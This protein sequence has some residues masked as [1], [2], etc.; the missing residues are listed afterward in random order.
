MSKAAYYLP[1]YFQVLGSSAT[2]AGVRR[3]RLTVAFSLV[4]YFLTDVLVQNAAVLSW[5]CAVLRYRWRHHYQ[6]RVL[7][8]RLMGGLCYV[9][10]WLWLDD[11]AEQ[12][13]HC[14]RALFVLVERM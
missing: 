7:A 10:A 9:H 2:G 11:S 1:M 5:R 6:N 13:F 12:L 3:V 8:P 4:E 14:V